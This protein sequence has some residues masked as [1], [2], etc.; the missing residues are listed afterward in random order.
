VVR[1]STPESHA[2][3]GRGQDD[4]A[5]LLDAIEAVQLDVFHIASHTSTAMI[6]ETEVCS[7]AFS[8]TL[9]AHCSLP[10]EAIRAMPPHSLPADADRRRQMAL[11]L[12]TL[13]PSLRTRAL[14]VSNDLARECL[15]ACGA[16]GSRGAC[17]DRGWSRSQPTQGRGG[18]DAGRGGDRGR[19]PAIHGG[20]ALPRYVP[21]APPSH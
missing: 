4:Q 16:S 11:Q 8:L 9:V 5:A 14:L 21:V 18:A 2:R 1:P 17:A 15:G 19:A 10:Q 7:S 12:L 3:E 20:G 6:V 13:R